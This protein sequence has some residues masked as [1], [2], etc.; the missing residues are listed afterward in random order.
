MKNVSLNT[1][2][3]NNIDKFNKLTLIKQMADN[4]VRISNNEST[5][6]T[7][8]GITYLNIGPFK[9]KFDGSNVEYVEICE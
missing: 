8:E 1:G 4:I 7:L 5:D 3:S 2:L 9:L 6:D